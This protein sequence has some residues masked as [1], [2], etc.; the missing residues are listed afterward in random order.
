MQ[1]V[2]IYNYEIKESVNFSIWLFDTGSQI[3][4]VKYISGRT[5]ISQPTRYLQ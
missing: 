5:T 1:K 2:I 4:Y 3:N